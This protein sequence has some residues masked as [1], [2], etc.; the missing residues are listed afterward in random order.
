MNNPIFIGGLER[1]GKTYMRMMLSA[2]PCGPRN[3]TATAI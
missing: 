1:S 3:T 2:H